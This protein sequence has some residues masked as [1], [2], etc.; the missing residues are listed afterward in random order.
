[1]ASDL[2][3]GKFLESELELKLLKH[4]C[5]DKMTSGM[6]GGLIEIGGMNECKGRESTKG[7]Q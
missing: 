1:V 2:G 3:F 6:T 5:L 7:G 4:L